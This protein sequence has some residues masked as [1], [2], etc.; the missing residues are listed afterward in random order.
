FADIG[1]FIE[2]PIKSYSSGMVVRL[3]FAVIAHVDA[4]ILVIDEALSVGD[5][6]FVQK[7]MRFLRQFMQHGTVLFVSHDTSAVLNLCE[8]AVWL[9][10][11][12][13]QAIGEPKDVTSQYL[14]KLYEEDFGA[15][16]VKGSRKKYNDSTRATRVIRDMR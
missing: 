5:A 1:D 2:Q 9:N 3:A 14:E 13:V 16:A 7:C 6:F 4:D 8:K 12:N 11:G 10:K 15:P